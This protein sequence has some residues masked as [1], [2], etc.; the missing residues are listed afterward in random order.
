[1]RS[2][3]LLLAGIL[4]GFAAILLAQESPIQGT[5][6]D[7][8]NRAIA[9]ATVQVAGQDISVTTGSDGHFSIAGN[10]S[11]EALILVS[12]PGWA[13][14]WYQWHRGT[15]SVTIYL[16]PHR[17][18]EQVTVT[19][20]TSRSVTRF[21]STELATAPAPDLDTLLRQVPGF[22]LFRRTPSWSANPTTQGVSLR[23]AG[24][25]GTS[26]AVVALNG[27][28][29][30]DPF[31]GWIYW[32]RVSPEILDAAVVTQGGASD[33]FGTEALGGAIELTRSHPTTRHL[34]A[35]SF[36]GNLFTPGGALVGDAK[37]G[38]WWEGGAV[39]LFRSN[40]YVPAS[41]DE[42]GRVDTVSNSENASGWIQIDRDFASGNRIFIAGNLYGESRQNGTE[43]QFNSATVRELRIGGDWVRVGGGVLSARMYGGTE[44]L[45]QTFT[46]VAADR[47]TETLTRDQSVPV[48]QWGLN[49]IWTRDI[50]SRQSVVAG[51]NA[52]WIE[53]ASEEWAYAQGVRNS[54]VLSGGSQR[55]IAGFAQDSIRLSNRALLSASLRVDGWWNIDASTR[56]LPVGTT[57]SPSVTAYQDRSENFASPRVAITYSA[58]NRLI[59]RGSFSRAFRSPTLNELYR[60]F[61]VG[62]VLTISNAFLS[63]EK[64][65]GAE[66]G[67]AYAVSDSQSLSVTYFWSRIDDPVS[68]RTLTILPSLITRQRQNLGTL[69]STGVE[70]SWDS[71][72]TPSISTSVAYQFAD[73]IVSE[74]RADPSLVGL[75]IPQVARNNATAELRFERPG[76]LALVVGGRYQGLQFDDDRNLFP[77]G[78]YF[79]AE[80]YASKNVRRNAQVFAGIE[81]LFNRRYEVART[82]VT[83][84][85]PPILA[86]IGVRFTLQR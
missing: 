81:N 30:N 26:R 51:T 3:R 75:W 28:P 8:N 68:N 7:R 18:D 56:T 50:G 27:V 19:G 14:S 4:L 54:R 70:A 61:R 63:S 44:D 79:V 74:F 52:G 5:V 49:A 55:R 46:A 37:T 78:G 24:A 9:N 80:A 47:N 60:S 22:S 62:N 34:T 20:E 21:S 73:A 86:R 77:L 43:R 16:T 32:G 48:S 67:A 72:W 11:D 65:T 1:M 35:S 40:G 13:P 66:A 45:R 38:S 41:P 36:V 42:R 58:T 82:P 76:K 69:R 17:V 12:A 84:I 83:M 6:R 23:G 59:L 33:I 53:G 71:R 64:Q 15:G 57:I 10:Q 25:S 39:A 85:G 29:L 31:G 2:R